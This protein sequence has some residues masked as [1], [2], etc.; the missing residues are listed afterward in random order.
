MLLP[1]WCPP[2]F[3]LARFSVL[4][5]LLVSKDKIAPKKKRAVSKVL[6]KERQKG[7]SW[8]ERSWILYINS[9][10]CFQVADSGRDDYRPQS[11]CIE[12]YRAVSCCI[13]LY[14]VVSSCIVLYRAVSCCIVLYRAVSCC[15]VLYRAVSCCIVL[16]RAVSCCI[17]LYRV[18]SCCIVL[19]R[20]VLC[21]IVLYRAV[22][23]YDAARNICILF[24]ILW[25]KQNV[26]CCGENEF[27]V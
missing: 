26:A 13:V 12:L 3:L 16:Y 17:V 15:I 2:N 14:R 24:L 7:L 8:R 4:W 20:A 10:N 9:G 21:C 19:Y 23:P 1:G 18:V 6:H 27:S 11:C 5:L 25:R 22:F